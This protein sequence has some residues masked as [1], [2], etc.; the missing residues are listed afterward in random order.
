MDIAIKM[1]VPAY[2]ALWL[3]ITLG[4]LL[5]TVSGETLGMDGNPRRQGSGLV[6]PRKTINQG[7]GW[8]RIGV[9]AASQ[10]GMNGDRPLQYAYR[11]GDRLGKIISTVGQV[12]ANNLFL[13]KVESKAAFHKELE[14]VGT[15]IG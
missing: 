3:W 2:L 13:I 9:I 7:D 5:R 10:K 12:D 6:S 11:D 15:R 4:F 8:I 14:K 1:Q